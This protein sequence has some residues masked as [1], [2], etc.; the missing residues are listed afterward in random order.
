[1]DSLRLLWSERV[2]FGNSDVTI[3][4]EDAAL[5]PFSVSGSNSQFMIIAFGKV[6]L[7]NEYTITISDSVVSAETGAAI[8]GDND[9]LAGGDA[10]LTM[11][12]R[13]PFDHDRDGDVDLL[14]FGEFQAAFTGP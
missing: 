5:V 4:N 11:E 13:D 3:T 8:D 14:D 9:G 12:H 2:L 10:V 1:V 7:N 6:L